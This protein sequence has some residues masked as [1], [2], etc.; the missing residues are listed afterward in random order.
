MNFASFSK[1]R[2]VALAGFLACV[3]PRVARCE[4]SVRY[5]YQDYA[6]SG[7][8]IA[9]TVSSAAVEKDLGTDMHLKLEG[10][11]DAI[12]GATPNGQP[13]P[14]GS[15][16][17]PLSHLTERRKAWNAALSRQIKRVNLALGVANSR[18]SD[19]VS[20]GWSVNTLTDFNQKNT[21]LLAGIAGT[22]D[23]IKVFYQTERAKKRTN[24]IILGVTQLIDPQTTV[25]LNV[26]W[27]RQRGYLADPY[28]LVQKS[29][30]IIPGVS[31]PLTFSENRPAERDKWI[32]LLA[33]NRAFRE[34]RG[35]IDFSYRFYHD[36]YDTDSHTVDVGWFQNLGE[37][38]IVR[39]GVR[40]Y[41]QSAAKFYHYTLDGTS[42]VPVAGRPRPDGPF[43][44]SDYRLSAM[45]TYTYGLKVVW[46]PS[47]ALQ[48]DAAYERYDMRGTDH[49]TPQ[50][51]YC[52]ANIITVGAKFSW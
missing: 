27:G 14:A 2:P 17:V 3:T 42:V 45:Q 31:L 35:A 48:F 50:S 46:S 33:F 29:T 40:F 47:E 30:E 32:A 23:D 34:V 11:I 39:P 28:K 25:A 36:T 15:D 20:N 22:D 44:S 16:Q 18:E 49:V 21:T 8:R 6:E 43:Y 10:V 4:D 41:D 12:A 19:Y 52:S 7:G 13:A 9:V 51:A 5:K 24:D 38:V 26:S 1:A 37:H